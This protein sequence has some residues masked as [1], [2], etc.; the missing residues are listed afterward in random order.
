MRRTT[1]SP[2][3]KLFT[4]AAVL[5]AGVV[6]T[7][8]ARSPA[9][10]FGMIGFRG[11]RVVFVS[12]SSQVAMRDDSPAFLDV[13]YVPGSGVPE[14]LVRVAAGHSLYVWGAD[15]G[16]QFAPKRVSWDPRMGLSHASDGWNVGDVAVLR[17]YARATNTDYIVVLN[18]VGVR[19][20]VAEVGERPSGKLPFAEVSLDISVIDAKEGNRVWRSPAQGRA[21][22][23]S[24]PESLVP[25]AMD[26][27]VDNF[28][29]A[30]PEV[31]RWG[32]RDI[33]DRFH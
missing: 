33:V 25:K 13:P 7:G 30:L 24:A 29:A 3:T 6:M 4:V 17:G 27:A 18:R 21:E 2:L 26:L 14:T 22:S 16:S 15:C 20:G 11:M 12:D 10:S 5:A 31:H 19:R 8:C 9:E 32:C 28:F 23:S 1:S